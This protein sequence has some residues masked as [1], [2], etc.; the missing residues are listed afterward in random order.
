MY[1][2]SGNH[3]HCCNDLLLHGAD[4]TIVNLNGSTAFDLAVDN[5]STLGE[6]FCL[7]LTMFSI[8]IIKRMSFKI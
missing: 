3:P 7:K 2:A 6:T 1:A 8:P 4:I 5:N